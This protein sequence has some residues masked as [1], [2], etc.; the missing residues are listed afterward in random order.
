MTTIVDINGAGILNVL[1]SRKE[2][3]E[4][5]RIIPAILDFTNETQF[6]FDLASQYNNKAFTLLQTVYIDNSANANDAQIVVRSSG[7]SIP[8][9]KNSAGYYTVFCNAPPKI[10]I[11]STS[12]AVKV[13]VAL[14]NWFEDP[15]V[16][17]GF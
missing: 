15:Y 12:S 3:S 7:Q 5:R 17:T 2:P 6:D 13:G 1:S 16:W 14:L 10:S 11:I 4:G 9:P 8:V